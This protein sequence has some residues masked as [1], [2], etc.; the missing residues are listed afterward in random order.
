MQGTEYNYPFETGSLT[1]DTWTKVIKTIPGNSNLL[2]NHDN[3]EGL[4]LD[5]SMFFGTNF[6]DNSVTNDVWEAQHSTRMKDNDSTWY[7]TNDATLE[8][9][10][11]QLEVG[12]QVTPFEHRGENEELALCRDIVM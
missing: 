4:Y 5:T 2:F 6:T 8:V 12:T 10:S 9:T 7:T 3:L 11:V 1:A